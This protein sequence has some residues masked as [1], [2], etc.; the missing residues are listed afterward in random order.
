MEAHKL[1]CAIYLFDAGTELAKDGRSY[2]SHHFFAFADFLQHVEHLREAEDGAERT[3]V[4]TLAAVDTLRFVDVFDAAF[5]LAD[6][7][8][9]TSFFARNRDVD[10]GVIRTALVADPTAHAG[11]VVNPCLAGL[12]ADVDGSLRTVILSMTGASASTD[13]SYFVVD[14]D[15][16]RTCFI[17]YAH[18]FI[19][20]VSVRSTIQ[21][22]LCVF[23]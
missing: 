22:F 19:F 13:F 10:D 11:V 17:Y 23:R 6:G 21:C 2:A 8:H 9:R 16:S 18:N 12:G 4:H 14:L 15:A 7:L 1:E 20:R 3:S 5:V